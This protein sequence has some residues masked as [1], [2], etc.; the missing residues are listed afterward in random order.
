MTLRILG[1][2]KSIHTRPVVSRTDFMMK[3][4]HQILSEYHRRTITTSSLTYF[5]ETLGSFLWEG[6]EVVCF[7]V[8]FYKFHKWENLLEL[9]TLLSFYFLEHWAAVCP[10]HSIVEPL[11]CRLT[12]FHSHHFSHITVKSVVINIYIEPQH[13]NPG[14]CMRIFY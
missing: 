1:M 6:K 11:L 14:D 3:E 4:F 7:G 10:E 5:R 12:V 9:S 2:Q 13:Q 8:L